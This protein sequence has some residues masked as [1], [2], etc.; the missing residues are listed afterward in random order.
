M[1]ESSIGCLIAPAGGRWDM[2]GLQLWLRMCLPTLLLILVVLCQLYGL[3]SLGI[4]V[5]R[6]LSHL[7]YSPFI[8]L[9][10]SF[11]WMSGIYFIGDIY[12][13]KEVCVYNMLLICP[14][15]F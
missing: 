5:Q 12:E 10:C 2:H 8:A 7:Y 15:A 4:F 9:T 6:L 1:V 13:V 14:L 11:C 3:L